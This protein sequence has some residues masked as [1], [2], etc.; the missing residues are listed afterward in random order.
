MTRFTPPLRCGPLVRGFSRKP[1]I[2]S[3]GR[4]TSAIDGIAGRASRATV[5]RLGLTRIC[6]VGGASRMSTISAG[7]VR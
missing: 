3:M 4:E 2:R 1:A 7:G 6:G 5:S